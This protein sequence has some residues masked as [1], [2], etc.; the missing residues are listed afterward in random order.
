MMLELSGVGAQI[1]LNKLRQPASAF[2]RFFD[3]LCCFP[4]YGFILSVRPWHVSDVQHIFHEYEI[5]CS[6]IGKVT[7]GSKVNLV[8]ED[9]EAVLWDF[10]DEPFTGFSSSSVAQNH[11]FK[12]E[13]LN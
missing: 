10:N 7:A 3:W 1:N 12:E 6:S 9:Q 11:E 5:S 2:D 4:S 8:S 13:L